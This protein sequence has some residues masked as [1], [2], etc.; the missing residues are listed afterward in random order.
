MFAGTSP[1]RDSLMRAWAFVPV[2]GVI[3]LLAGCSVSPFNMLSDEQRIDLRDGAN[4]Y[5][6]EVLADL[7]VDETEYRQAAEDWHSCVSSS[8]AE[9]SDVT[10]KGN[11]LTFDVTIQAATDMAVAS[12]QTVAHACLPQYFDAIGRVWVSQGSTLS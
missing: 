5:Q 10:Q 9:P 12:V 3:A 7:V 6:Q 1:A 2:L 8:G 4:A 11:E